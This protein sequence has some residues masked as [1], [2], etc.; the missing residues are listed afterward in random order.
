MWN[1][2][3]RKRAG[4]AEGSGVPGLT[5][6]N[7]FGVP[8]NSKTAGQAAYFRRPNCAGDDEN[9]AVQ[10]LLRKG[11]K[12]LGRLKGTSAHPIKGVPS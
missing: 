5:C 1:V 9:S 2:G 3:L 7:I 12:P 11:D 6:A 10:G 4:W 8:E